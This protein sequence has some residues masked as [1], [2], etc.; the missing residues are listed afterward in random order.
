MTFLSILF[1]IPEKTTNNVNNQVNVHSHTYTFKYARAEAR[2][3]RNKIC[4]RIFIICKNQEEENKIKLH[5]FTFFKE[6]NG[7]R[8]EVDRRRTRY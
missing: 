1:K 5:F 7:G 6:K 2:Q 8:N 3:Y 4:N